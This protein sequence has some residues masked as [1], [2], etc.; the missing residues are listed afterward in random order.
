MD[1]I[2]E[3]G[4]E[5]LLGKLASAGSGEHLSAQENVFLTLKGA[6]ER[7]W[8]FDAA[9]AFAMNRL[10]P[11]QAGGEVDLEQAMQLREDRQ[12]LEE[13]RPYYRATFEGRVPTVRERAQ[14][15]AAGSNRVDTN[16]RPCQVPQ[17]QHAA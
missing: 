15:L 4:L 8:G 13:D 11:S 17:R 12:L 5:R 7:G 10:Q 6:R 1:G 14:R 2:G 3:V 16:F 9:W